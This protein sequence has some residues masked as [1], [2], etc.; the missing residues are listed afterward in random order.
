MGILPWEEPPRKGESEGAEPVLHY[1]AVVLAQF[2]AL[3]GAS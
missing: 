3:S 2:T 1:F